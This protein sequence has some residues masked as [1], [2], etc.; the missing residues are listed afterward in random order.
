MNV[1]KRIFKA[2]ITLFVMSATLFSS[3]L[4]PSAQRAIVA[5]PKSQGA[6][7]LRFPRIPISITI[8]RAKKNCGGF[9]ICR[10]TI[11]KASAAARLVNGE[12][13]A[14]G[15]GKLL[16]SLL[17]KTPEE[18]Q[19]L[20]VDQDITLSQA[21]AQKLGFKSVTIQQGEYAFSARKALLSARLSK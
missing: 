14:T 17:Q 8:G 21:L 2:A 15:D 11:G 16:L 3:S 7:A 1:T 19:T 20:F 10:I 12:L 9:G 18:E 4:W 13:S 6:A 5:S